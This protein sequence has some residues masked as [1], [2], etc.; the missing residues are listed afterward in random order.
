MVQLFYTVTLRN[1]FVRTL[2]VWSVI[3]FRE[4]GVVHRITISFICLFSICFIY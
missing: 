2:S 1:F 4:T 3:L